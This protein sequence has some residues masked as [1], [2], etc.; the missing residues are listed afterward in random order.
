MK[1]LMR[2]ITQMGVKHITNADTQHKA[3]I[4]CAYIYGN[5]FLYIRMCVGSHLIRIFLWC[6]FRLHLAQNTLEWMMQMI[7]SRACHCRR[8]GLIYQHT[9]SPS[10][11]HFGSFYYYN[12]KTITPPSPLN[13]R[14]AFLIFSALR[15]CAHEKN[16]LPSC[17]RKSE[18]RACV[19]WLSSV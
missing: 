16:A 13:S 6:T 17:H 12:H 4:K 10:C 19:G 7:D 5:W 11:Q 3:Y 9:I 18:G 8:F 14:R 1:N 15:A 2:T